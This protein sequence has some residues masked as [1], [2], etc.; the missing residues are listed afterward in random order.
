MTKGDTMLSAKS[1][2]QFLLLLAY[3]AAQPR[4]RII[5]DHFFLAVPG[6]A[7]KN[8]ATG[9]LPFYDFA[10]GQVYCEVSMDFADPDSTNFVTFMLQATANLSA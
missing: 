1:T 3:A 7:A 5:N 10:L 8:P 4:F 9:A 2:V 6:E